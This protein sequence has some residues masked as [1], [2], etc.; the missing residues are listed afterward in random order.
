MPTAV[1]YILHID[2]I[3]TDTV[4]APF[5]SYSF[6]VAN[7]GSQ[8]SG[9]GA[10]AG[11]VTTNSDSFL[12]FYI[13]K[14]TD[15][16]SARLL[17]ACITGQLIAKVTL[18]LLPTGQKGTASPFLVVVLKDVFV[19]TISEAGNVHGGV[20]LEEI[21]FSFRSFQV[22]VDGVTAGYDIDLEKVT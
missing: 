4:S 5:E 16:A 17:K 15:K 12:S 3:A 6:S 10:G 11:K 7:I 9:S 22:T 13:T 1:E 19:S 2:G 20:P 21:V 8:A 18:E 14:K